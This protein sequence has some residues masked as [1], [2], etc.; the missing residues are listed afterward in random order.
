MLAT[1]RVM[2]QRSV[3][4]PIVIGFSIGVVLLVVLATTIYDRTIEK[5]KA[6]SAL[7]DMPA[8]RFP[9]PALPGQVVATQIEAAAEMENHNG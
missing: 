1:L 7:P 5:A 2:S 4:R 9:I 6:A 8:P 3:S